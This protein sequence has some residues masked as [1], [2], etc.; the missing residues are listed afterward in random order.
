MD[1]IEEY[2]LVP[3]NESIE[4]LSLIVH[5]TDIREESNM[6]TGDEDGVLAQQHEDVPS[7]LI[8]SRAP[9]TELSVLEALV[10]NTDIEPE[11]KGP[12]IGPHSNDSLC[13]AEVLFQDF[14]IHALSS[15]TLLS[16]FLNKGDIEAE[17]LTPL[18]NSL[19]KLWVLKLKISD[20]LCVVDSIHSRAYVT[21]NE[22]L[23]SDVKHVLRSCKAMAPVDKSNEDYNYEK[24]VYWNLFRSLRDTLKACVLSFLKIDQDT[25]VVGIIE[26]EEPPK[27]VFD[28]VDPLSRYYAFHRGT[29]PHADRGELV[30]ELLSE[31]EEAWKKMGITSSHAKKFSHPFLNLY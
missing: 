18:M 21:I 1:T 15:L 2:G 30:K 25:W 28:S 29:Y 11:V 16:D 9:T 26:E 13:A 8:M 7:E 5:D 6:H 4:D 23:E 24:G 14:G 19:R 17:R 12:N 3:L 27:N 20:L 10:P 31:R 22:I